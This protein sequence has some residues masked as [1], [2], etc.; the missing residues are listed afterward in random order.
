MELIWCDSISIVRIDFWLVFLPSFY[1][2]V[3]TTWKFLDT[4]GQDFGVVRSD[5]DSFDVQLFA[6]L[7]LHTFKVL[8]DLFEK[9]TIIIQIVYFVVCILRFQRVKILFIR[10]LNFSLFA[11]SKFSES[12][13]SCLI[14]L[15]VENVFACHSNSKLSYFLKRN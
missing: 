11:W 1:P 9:Q 15:F 8:V 12:D 7:D 4:F 10:L 5:V 6:L 13:E 3:F 2:K 14:E